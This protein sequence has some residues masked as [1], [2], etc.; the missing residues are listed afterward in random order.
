[1]LHA[2]AAAGAGEAKLTKVLARA[3]WADLSANA[4]WLVVVNASSVICEKQG[5]CC[6]P[7]V[8]TRGCDARLGAS[9]WPCTGAIAIAELAVA[10]LFVAAV[11]TGE[12]AAGGSHDLTQ[13]ALVGASALFAA[14]T[15]GLRLSQDFAGASAAFT[16]FGVAALLATTMFR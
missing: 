10:G 16:Y 11:V 6:M 4:R 15:M 9:A 13:A 2:T 1:M 12:S 14:L 3:D 8:T 7:C 5:R